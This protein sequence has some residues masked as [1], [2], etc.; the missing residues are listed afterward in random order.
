[1]H[2]RLACPVALLLVAC[3]GGSTGDL[4]LV[5][6]PTTPLPTQTSA[7]VLVPV[8]PTTLDG[9]PGDTTVV[10]VRA[11]RSDGTPVHAVTIYFQVQAGGGVVTPLSATTDGDGLVTT[12]WTFGGIPGVNLLNVVGGFVASPISFTASTA[13]AQ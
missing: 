4:P 2:L 3:V 5:A 8:S 12:K 6:A 10:Q 13:V 1:M 7:E 11:T 9:A